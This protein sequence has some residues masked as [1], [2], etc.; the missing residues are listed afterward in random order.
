MDPY[1][2]RLWKR[3]NVI[4]IIRSL[5]HSGEGNVFNTVDGSL[6]TRMIMP[7]QNQL[8]LTA[9]SY[10]LSDCLEILDDVMAF[11]KRVKILVDTHDTRFFCL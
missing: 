3:K 10:D 9:L 4:R 5:T 6:R 11:N 7:L 2:C 1:L 8:D